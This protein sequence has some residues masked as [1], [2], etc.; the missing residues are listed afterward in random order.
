MM[1]K[2]WSMRLCRISIRQSSMI[3]CIVVRTTIIRRRKEVPVRQQAPGEVDAKGV[4][5]APE[6][7]VCFPAGGSLPRCRVGLRIN[8][9]LKRQRRRNSFHTASP[10]VEL[11]LLVILGELVERISFS[12]A[13]PQVSGGRLRGFRGCGDVT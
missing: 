2:L 9:R 1:K 5:D 4:R 11:T 3:I 13:M 7:C 10:A 6:S 8:G 12:N